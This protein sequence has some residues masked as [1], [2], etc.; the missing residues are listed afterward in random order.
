[1]HYSINSIIFFCIISLSLGQVLFKQ[2]AINYSRYGLFYDI[3]VI[4]VL[5]V[6]AILYLTSTILWIWILRYVELSKVYPYFALA[7]VFVPLLGVCFFGEA[8]TVRYGVGVLLIVAG[9]A[10]TSFS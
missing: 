9:V 5:A 7:F 6:A 4:G 10:M 3:R 8:L 2:V 1:M